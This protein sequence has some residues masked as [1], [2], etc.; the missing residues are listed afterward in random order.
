[1]SAPDVI[2]VGAGVAGLSCAHRVAAAGLGVVVLEAS[3]GVG[4]RVRTDEVDG[5][6]LDRGFQVLPTAYGE[7]RALLDYEDLDLRPLERGAVVQHGGRFHALGDPRH[8]PLGALR[9]LASGSV[10]PGDALAL[11]RLLGRRGPET[12]AAQVVADVGLSDVGEQLLRAFLRGIFLERELDTSSE[13]LEFVLDAFSRGAAALPAR[14]MGAIAKQLADGLD[15]RLEM[16][17]A[18]VRELEA[19][20]VVVAAPGLLDEHEPAWNGV[21]CVYFDAPEPP[22]RGAS[23]LLD[24]ADSGPVNNLCVL[25]EVAETYAPPGRALV[26]A[27]VLG[28]EEP[29]LRAVRRQLAGWFGPAVGDWRHLRTDVIARALPAYHVGQPLECAPR[30]S[31]GLYACGDHRLHPSLDGALRSGRLAAEAVV[32]DLAR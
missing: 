28:G 31:D 26:S 8:G 18:D 17:I 11:R 30:V 20:A 10:R 9:A 16:R 4:G 14:G 6:L 12:T 32:A 25:S 21:S 3:D 29:A 7:A 2:V 24:G 5:F 19:T 1:M 27:S 23:L 15:V 13:F 22:W